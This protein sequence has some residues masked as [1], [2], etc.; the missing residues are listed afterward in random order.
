ME[1]TPEMWAAVTGFV[2]V[3]SASFVKTGL[4]WLA[5]YV[6]STPTKWDDR[7]YEAVRDGVEEAF[8][9]KDWEDQK[10]ADAKMPPPNAPELRGSALR[11]GE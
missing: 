10:A 5:A 8:A 9:D 1:M 11:E 2:A 7:V 4:R 6:K 3:F